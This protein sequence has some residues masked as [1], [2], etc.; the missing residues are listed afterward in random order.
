MQIGKKYK[1]QTAEGKNIRYVA[2]ELVAQLQIPTNDEGVSTKIEAHRTTRGNIVF[3]KV[4]YRHQAPVAHVSDDPDTEAEAPFVD[5]TV[6]LEPFTS[7]EAVLVGIANDAVY[8][9]DGFA[10]ALHAYA[11]SEAAWTDY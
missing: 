4:M 8:N 9:T 3:R 6:V 5:K 11:N 10:E 7:L 2:S 1:G